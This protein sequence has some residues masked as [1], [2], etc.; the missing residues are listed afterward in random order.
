MKP[1]TKVTFCETI[2][3]SLFISMSLMYFMFQ[4]AQKNMNNNSLF[5]AI[6]ENVTYEI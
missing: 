6:K 3:F 4:I 5:N 1:Q 2:G